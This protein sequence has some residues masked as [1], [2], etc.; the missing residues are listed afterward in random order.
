MEGFNGGPVG[1]PSRYRL[2]VL[3]YSF[4]SFSGMTKS[5]RGELPEEAMEK[6]EIAKRL[7][8]IREKSYGLME[9]HDTFRDRR[10]LREALVNLCDLI[11]ELNAEIEEGK[12][13][14]GRGPKGYG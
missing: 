1:I 13:P 6:E 10:M 8:Y 9:G 5:N 3:E 2:Y 12:Q 11:E 7:S 4:P 14:E